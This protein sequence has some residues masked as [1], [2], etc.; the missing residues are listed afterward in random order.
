MTT[1]SQKLLLQIERGHQRIDRLSVLPH[2]RLDLQ[3]AVEPAVHVYKNFFVVVL[4][5]NGIC[6]YCHNNVT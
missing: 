1:E 6:I 5:I 3:T 4:L 2:D